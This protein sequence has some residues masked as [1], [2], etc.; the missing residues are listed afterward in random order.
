MSLHCAVAFARDTFRLNLALDVTAG[1]TVLV[2]PNGSGKSTLLRLLSGLE[3]PVQGQITLAD[4]A[5]FD[6][7]RGVNLPPQARRIGMVFQS[8]ELF[9]HLSVAGNI[10]YGMRAL[11]FSKA[12]RNSE[13][14]RLLDRIGI[15][16][17][18]DRPVAALSG[19]QRQK[20]ALARAMAVAPRA[21]L[22]D[23]PLSALDQAGRWEM[24]HWLFDTLTEW[25]IPTLLV[26]HDPADA[27]FF[28][29]R[30]VVME[31]GKISQQ[32]SFHQLL[33]TPRTAFI[34]DFAGVNY[35]PG[36]VTFAEGNPV[37]VGNGGGQFSAPFESVVAGAACLTITPREI[38]L[39]RQPPGGSP[40][41]IM[42][43][44]VRDVMEMGSSVRVTVVGTE[45]L[46]AELSLRG[47]VAIDRPAPGEAIYTVFKTRETRV[48]NC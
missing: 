27:A 33:N 7:E 35:L 28:R 10:A 45:K 32:G 15:A 37:F 21:L 47:Y 39:Y 29:K 6:S 1:I 22:L 40:C 26:S 46:V 13:V 3:R 20:V 25:Q 48:E 4:V 36:E 2:G 12:L 34:A 24:R 9:P 8:L 5:L 16:D 11:G 19:G 42:V 43:G 30:I 41:N 18:A 14:A 23:E 38:A 17:F 31:E 44:T